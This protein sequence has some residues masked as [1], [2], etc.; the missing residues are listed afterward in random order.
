MA[1]NDIAQLSVVGTVGTQQHVHTL[2]FRYLTAGAT[3]NALLVAWTATALASY[4]ARFVIT[5]TPVERLAARQVAGTAPFRAPAE[6][7]PSPN[8]GLRSAGSLGEPN[9]TWLA[10]LVSERTALAGKRY[11]GRF[12]LGGLYEWDV[13]GNNLRLGLAETPRNAFDLGQDYINAL[14]TGYGPSGTSTDY[15]LFVFSRTLSKVPGTLPQN[16]GADITG[17]LHRTTVNSMQSRRPGSG[18]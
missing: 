2:H 8:A 11:R 3:D 1:V 9:P 15:R 10:E 4:K 13:I 17:L 16:Q 7:A 6:S 5:D 12:Y 18:S 14:L